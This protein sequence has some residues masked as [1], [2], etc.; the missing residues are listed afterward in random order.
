MI[1]FEKLPKDI[2]AR[3][4]GLH[5]ALRDDSNAVFAYLFGSLASGSFGPL[6]DVDVA[7]YVNDSREQA[8]YK[9]D[10]FDRLSHAIGTD[11]IDL[12][13]LNQAPISL[14]G[15]V[16]Q[17]GKTVLDKEPFRRYA[18]ESLVRREYFDFRIKEEAFFRRRYSVG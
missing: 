7:V 10:L 18:Y 11:E 12:V 16:L 15:R 8:E 17:H 1:R 4:T 9:L 13:I 2:A 3:L 14:A 6:S 5:E